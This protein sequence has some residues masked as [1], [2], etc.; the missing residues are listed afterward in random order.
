MNTLLTKLE[1]MLY[2]ILPKSSPLFAQFKVTQD[3]RAF[4]IDFAFPVL[5]IGFNVDM[6]G[7]SSVIPEDWIIMSVTED[8]LKLHKNALVS[9]IGKLMFRKDFQMELRKRKPSCIS[10]RTV[11]KAANVSA[12]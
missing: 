10:L 4:L 2:D 1:R 11:N 3:G 6:P 5:K 8:D 9:E 7:E 12:S